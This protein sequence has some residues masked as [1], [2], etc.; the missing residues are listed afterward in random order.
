MD[1]GRRSLPRVCSNRG[2]EVFAV[3]L[4]AIRLCPAQIRIEGSRIAR[5]AELNFGRDI[6]EQ[7]DFKSTGHRGGNLGLKFQ[8]IAQ[9]PVIGLRPRGREPVQTALINCTVMRMVF[10]ER[11]HAPFEDGADVELVGNGRNIR[12]FF[13]GE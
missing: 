8:H 13:E 9:V 10:A 11:L 2:W 12:V 1:R 3:A 6:A 5:P 4:R 7:C